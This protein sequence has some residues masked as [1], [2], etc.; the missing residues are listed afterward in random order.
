MLPLDKVIH[1][2]RPVDFHLIDGYNLALSTG[3]AKTLA[4]PGN[5]ERA[6]EKLIG[7]V[8]AR[9][10]EPWRLRTTIVFD[11]Q[12]YSVPTALAEQD[13][14]TIRFALD[15]PNA[16]ALLIEL[17]RTHAAP[18]Q[19]VVVSSDREIQYAARQ[20]G[21]RPVGSL[22]WFEQVERGSLMVRP[23]RG[24]SDVDDAAAREAAA[25]SATWSE[26]LPPEI[27]AQLT[28][29]LPSRPTSPAATEKPFHPPDNSR[30]PD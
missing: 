24:D 27:L 22:D 28:A 23:A 19:L 18:K 13:G 16:D 1:V 12:R 8:R 11:A 25:R 3:L 17:I 7:W 14:L 30:N 5:L 20:R 9:A 2:S 21:A 29:R 15:Y 6:R 4:G 10:D 26:L